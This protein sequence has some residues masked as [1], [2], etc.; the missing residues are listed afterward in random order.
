MTWIILKFLVSSC[1][2][3]TCTD[4]NYFSVCYKYNFFLFV[5][6]MFI[7]LLS[8]YL[9]SVK[10]EFGTN[11]LCVKLSFG[12]RYV[13]V[14]AFMLTT[15]Y[16]FSSFSTKPSSSSKTR[17]FIDTSPKSTPLPLLS[18]KFCNQIKFFYLVFKIKTVTRDAMWLSQ[19]RCSNDIS[20][21]ST[22]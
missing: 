8:E 14:L 18:Q 6:L 1:C 12:F 17:E 22:P 15:F 11:C 3:L 7:V 21:S 19:W 20:C 16:L 10:L 13:L 9:S 4:I 5:I 2:W